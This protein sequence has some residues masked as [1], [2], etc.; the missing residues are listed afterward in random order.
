MN[1]QNLQTKNSTLVAFLMILW[2]SLSARLRFFISDSKYVKWVIA[3]KTK[4][5]MVTG[6][7]FL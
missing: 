6:C 2:G 3:F 1:N 5:N 7:N 4:I